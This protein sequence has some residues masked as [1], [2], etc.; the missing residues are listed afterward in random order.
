MM[1]E[2]YPQFKKK[3]LA[4]FGRLPFSPP[5]RF[6]HGT[7][8]SEDQRSTDYATEPLTKML[9]FL[10]FIYVMYIYY[11]SSDVDTQSCLNRVAQ[12]YACFNFTKQYVHTTFFSLREFWFLRLKNIHFRRVL[13]VFRAFPVLG[14]IITSLATLEK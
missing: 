6:E 3:E 5:G 10:I 7:S 14:P 2:I 1:L 4:F 8:R 12:N 9:V 13:P 11:S